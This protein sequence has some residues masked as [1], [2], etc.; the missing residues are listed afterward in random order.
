M[1]YVKKEKVTLRVDHY[2]N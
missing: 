2:R 1:G